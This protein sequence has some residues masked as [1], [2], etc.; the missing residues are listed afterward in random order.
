VDYLA[1]GAFD[2]LS[3][4]WEAES[5]LDPVEFDT[6]RADIYPLAAMRLKIAFYN[7]SAT[8]V[9]LR[10]GEW[11]SIAVPLDFARHF[12]RFYFQSLLD[13]PAKCYFDNI[14]FT[15][16]NFRSPITR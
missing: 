11:N 15:A 13:T 2:L 16:A 9:S 1:R 8:E 7:D 14:R 3:G 4:T 12:S 6:L 5:P 10:G